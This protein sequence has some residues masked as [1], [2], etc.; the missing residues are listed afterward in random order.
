MVVESFALDAMSTQFRN[1]SR[2]RHR[3]AIRRIVLLNVRIDRLEGIYGPLSAEQDAQID[4]LI[5]RE[6]EMQV[7][8]PPLP[9]WFYL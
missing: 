3:E 2:S 5:Y 9:H 6:N 7:A 4:R 1:R 8:W